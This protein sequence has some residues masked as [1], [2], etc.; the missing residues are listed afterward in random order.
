MLGDRYML[1]MKREFEALKDVQEAASAVEMARK[2]GTGE[3]LYA[4]LDELSKALERYR[5]AKEA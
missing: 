4:M 1:V 3:A 5:E 2:A